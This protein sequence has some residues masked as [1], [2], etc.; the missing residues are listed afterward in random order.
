[1]C[2][3]DVTCVP[4]CLGVRSMG[5]AAVLW[6]CYSMHYKGEILLRLII[7][8]L[9]FSWLASLPAS[10]SEQGCDLLLFAVALGLSRLCSRSCA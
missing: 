5:L 9:L 10:S 6:A 8:G 1:M 7:A 3:C 4:A 2:Q